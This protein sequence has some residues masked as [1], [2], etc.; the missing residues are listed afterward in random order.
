MQTVSRRVERF[1]QIFGFAL[2]TAC[3]PNAVN[4]QGIF[5]TSRP[6]EQECRVWANRLNADSHSE[7][8]RRALDS[9]ISA[10]GSLGGE[11]IAT[12][13]RQAKGS[14]LAEEFRFVVAYNRNPVLLAAL[15]EVAADP[16]ATDE[17]RL[18]AIEGTLRQHD[19]ASAFSRSMSELAS[20][21]VGDD[22]EI[23]YVE[24]GG[25]YKSTTPLPGDSRTT[26][27]MSLRRVA[28]DSRNH[29]AV[30]DAARC[31]AERLSR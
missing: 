1:A 5:A 10:C 8:F 30:R 21:P 26:T 9:N 6:S 12:A 19:I 15:V 23:I 24:D 14:S 18:V 2:L 20:Q 17:M 11:A 13:I 28:D 4:G 7:A 25:D 27:S 29:Q 16:S 31:V 3:A 22:C